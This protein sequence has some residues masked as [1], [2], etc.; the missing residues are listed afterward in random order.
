MLDILT[1]HVLFRADAIEDDEHSV[2][3]EHKTNLVK[4]DDTL[5]VMD[6]AVD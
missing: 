1:A 3:I 4:V 2:I 5:G 6:E